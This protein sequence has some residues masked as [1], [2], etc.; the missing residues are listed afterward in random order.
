MKQAENIVSRFG[1]L[2]GTI[3]PSIEEKSSW[4]LDDKVRLLG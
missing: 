2:P 4:H 1:L 3:C